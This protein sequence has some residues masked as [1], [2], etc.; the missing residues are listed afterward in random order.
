M[1]W[2]QTEIRAWED[3]RIQNNLWK[4]IRGTCQ[5]SQPAFLPSPGK[6]W[7]FVLQGT[8]CHRQWNSHPVG[9]ERDKRG[10]IRGG[11]CRSAATNCSWLWEFWLFGS[12]WWEEA[13]WGR[14]AKWWRR[15]AESSQSLMPTLSNQYSH[16]PGQFKGWFWRALEQ[17]WTISQ[18]CSQA[19]TPRN[20]TQ[21]QDLSDR[22]SVHTFLAFCWF[23]VNLSNQELVPVFL[24]NTNART[25]FKINSI[26]WQN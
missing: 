13:L 14:K 2:K 12:S 3:V 17:R 25:I 20:P 26:I 16:I 1:N 4:T 6:P 8:Q 9:G 19:V 21:H 7:V 15:G 23:F 10:Q 11:K 18:F 22:P 24:R 5:V